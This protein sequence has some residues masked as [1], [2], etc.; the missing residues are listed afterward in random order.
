[1]FDDHK[2]INQESPIKEK[3]M[4]KIVKSQILIRLKHHDFS[5][6]SKN[7]DIRLWSYP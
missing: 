7:I 3:N 1:M 2:I 4:A 6:N 5:L